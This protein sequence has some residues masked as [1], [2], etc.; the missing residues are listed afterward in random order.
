MKCFFH[1]FFWVP[2]I[3]LT[4]FFVWLIGGCFF[5]LSIS[6]I[7]PPPL[8]HTEGI[9]VFTGEKGRVHQAMALY[10]KGWGSF[11]HISGH[12]KK[13]P[14]SPH[15][16]YDEAQNTQENV[17]FAL[18]WIKKHRVRSV[19]LVTSDYHMPR[20]LALARPIWQVPII[21]HP[22]HLCLNRS[23]RIPK[24]FKEYNKWLWI[25]AKFLIDFFG[26]FL[27]GRESYGR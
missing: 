5:A 20:C 9:V 21:P 17:I 18:A 8:E 22:L 6:Q 2:K 7:Q 3:I 1:F 25:K 13:K 26:A 11:L 10:H 16:S 23:T 14:S 24:I 15:I 19:R 12:R 4:L 27:R